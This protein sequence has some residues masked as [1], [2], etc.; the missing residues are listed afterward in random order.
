MRFTIRAGTSSSGVAD[1][2]MLRALGL[3][4]GGVIS[5]G[6]THTRVTGGATSGP[7][8]LLLNEETMKNAELHVGSSVDVKRVI[9]PVA[10]VV[11]FSE[12]KLEARALA[13]ALQGTPITAGDHIT[14][15]A[16]Y[17]D[18]DEDIE[19]TVTAVEPDIGVVGST[20]RFAIGNG[21]QRGRARATN[22]SPGIKYQRRSRR[23]RTPVNCRSAAGRSRQ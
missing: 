20:T 16:G 15:D 9:L 13:R 19:L 2:V 11:R 8:D 21:P 7:T 12:H 5:V 23:R 3:P 4:Y 17:F 10:E 22:N 14:I 1:S 18:G 6:K